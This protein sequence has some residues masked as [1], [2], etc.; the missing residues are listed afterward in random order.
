V[1]S[2]VRWARRTA[3]IAIRIASQVAGTGVSGH[4]RLERQPCALPGAGAG[5][6]VSTI[7][8]V[9]KASITIAKD[10]TVTMVLD[11]TT[12]TATA[13][14]GGQKVTEKVSIPSVQFTWAPKECDQT[15][16]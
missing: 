3:A 1:P 7:N 2:P 9:G 4:R 14:T 12:G 10:G 11:A 13:V 5:T 6:V 16:A 8:G 15:P